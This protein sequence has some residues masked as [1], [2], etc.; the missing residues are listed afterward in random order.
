MNAYTQ[1]VTVFSYAAAGLIVGG[2]ARISFGLRGFIV[3]STLGM[4]CYM[5]INYHII[6]IIFKQ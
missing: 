1:N 2:I 6:I 5:H 4:Y 3:G